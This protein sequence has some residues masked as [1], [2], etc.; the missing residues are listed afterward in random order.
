[1]F[2]SQH[3]INAKFLAIFCLGLFV[4][5]LAVAK[6]QIAVSQSNLLFEQ[7]VNSDTVPGINVAVADET[8]VV[9]AKGFGFADIENNVV[10]T[11]KH[12]MRIGSVA[13]LI[14]TAGM[15][16]LYDK[17]L[18]NLDVPVTN[19]VESWPKKHAPIT[20]RQLAAH[21]SGI[22]HY[23]GHEF[24]SNQAYSNV[25][26]SLNIFKQDPLRYQPGSKHS[27]TTY[28][29]SL[30]SAAM[31]GADG[32]RD[33]RQIIDEEVFTTLNMADSGFDDKFAIIKNRQRPYEV[34]N[35][36]ITNARQTDHSYKWAG[37]GF[38]A[39]P[40][41]VSRFA[42]AHNKPGYL[43]ETTLESM[44]TRAA[45]DNG[46]KLNYGI[47]WQL[48]FERYKNRSKYRNDPI[49]QKMMGRF[50]RVAMHSGGSM[51]GITMTILC[52][53]HGKAVTV[54]KN[55]SNERSVDVFL[56]ALKTLNNFHQDL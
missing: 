2:R 16:R 49:A 50:N 20:L 31:E 29:W 38:L 11:P 40:S 48:G 23:K 19:Y 13:K 33:F 26:E 46:R 4:S 17:G 14:A 34:K 5:T 35:G 42:V 7:A 3:L 32:K 12:K 54:V 18:I 28:G 21:T 52:R 25:E 24:L 8:G 30:V 37:G 51:G 39:S 45:L 9:W 22:R 47:G 43:K 1:M 10:M 53:D 56:L 6:N 36:V 41:D 55:V 44:F 27:Y 15:M